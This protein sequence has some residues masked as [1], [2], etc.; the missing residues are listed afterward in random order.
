VDLLDARRA[1]AVFAGE[2]ASWAL[3]AHGHDIAASAFDLPFGRFTPGAPADFVVL[4]PAIP[5]PLAG[6]SLDAH[7][8]RASARRVRHVVVAGD[9][10]VAGGRATR[11]DEREVRARA[12][13]HLE[14]IWKRAI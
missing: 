10:I 13:E 5:A 1:A 11:V 12:R 4:D 9:T 2:R 8:E 3:L 7:L 14:R 6:G